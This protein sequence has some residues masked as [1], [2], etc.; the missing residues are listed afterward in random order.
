MEDEACFMYLIKGEN[1]SFSDV[2]ETVVTEKEALLVKCGNF[3]S[4]MFPSQTTGTYEAIAVHFYPE[5]LTKIYANE[6]PGFLK[7]KPGEGPKNAM[8]SFK[9]DELLQKYFDSVL[10]Y[11]AN[12]E[13]VNEEL[14]IL[15]LK[16]LFLLLENTQNASTLHD[17]LSGLFSPKT[18]SFREII[19]AHLYADISL[20]DLAVLT[21]NSLSTFKREFRK[22]LN[23]SPGRYIKH[24]K[25]KKAAEMLLIGDQRVSEVAYTCGFNDVTGFSKSFREKYGVSPKS[26]RIVNRQN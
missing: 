10:F 26:Y 8:V 11:F 13:L 3:F 19:E 2:E 14:M 7:R 25:L 15:K 20:E 4:Q 9:T 18:Y 6:Y 5:V 21:N 17:I 16:E 23:D 1:R 24:K 12:P 22:I